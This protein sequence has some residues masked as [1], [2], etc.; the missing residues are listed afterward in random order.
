MACIC[1]FV[2]QCMVH[3]GRVDCGQTMSCG[4]G[5]LL[6]RNK[7]TAVC[8]ALAVFY[9]Q[10]MSTRKGF[11]PL[12]AAFLMRNSPTALIALLCYNPFIPTA[13]IF[14]CALCADCN[15]LPNQ[16]DRQNT[17]GHFTISYLA[18]VARLYF[19]VWPTKAK[20]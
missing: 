1:C 19:F 17:F 9:D 15:L 14:A 20:K 10:Q 11:G 3:E 8:N 7:C 4:G 16:L 6:H 5:V 2:L 18:M 13:I 12:F